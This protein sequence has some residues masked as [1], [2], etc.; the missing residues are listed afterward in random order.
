MSVATI[1]QPWFPSPLRGEGRSVVS[2][3][4]FVGAPTR[5]WTWPQGLQHKRCRT[6]ELPPFNPRQVGYT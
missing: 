6:L 1:A 3:I 4:P 5:R 2:D